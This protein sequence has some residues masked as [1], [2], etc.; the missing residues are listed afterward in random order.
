VAPRS[1]ESGVE[2]RRPCADVGEILFKPFDGLQE[3]I[4]DAFVAMLQL[5]DARAEHVQHEP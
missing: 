1:S 5:A 2:L 4:R 3:S